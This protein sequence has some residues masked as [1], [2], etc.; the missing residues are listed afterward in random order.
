M[1]DKKNK[2][3][4]KDQAKL[5][6][7]SDLVLK[8]IEY[9][10]EF[11]NAKPFRGKKLYSSK[12]FIH[13]GDNKSA[14]NLYY[15]ADY[16]VHYKCRS[17]GCEKNFGTSLLSMIRGGLSHVKYSWQYPGDKEVSFDDTVAFVLD[18]LQLDFGQ[19]KRSVIDTS[20]HDFCK[21]SQAI[22]REATEGVVSK[23]FYRSRVEIP[24][25]YYIDRGFSI[26]VLDEHDVGTCH[27]YDKPMFNRAMV[28]IYDE[29]ND[30]IVGFTGRSIFEKCSNC[31]SY[32]DPS[33]KCGFFPKWRHSKGLRA[34]N[35]LYN[36][37]KAKS[38]IQESY[39]IILVES[40]GNVW[41]LE[42]AGIHNSV[43]IFGTSLSNTQQ[44][45]IDESGAM[46]MLVIMDNDEPGKQAA[47]AIAEQ[48]HKTYNVQVVPIHSQDVG[49]M[50]VEEVQASIVPWIKKAS[51]N[52]ERF[53]K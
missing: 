28:P 11:F 17:H 14:L 53:L 30:K 5:N 22:N 47:Q 49:D 40:P 26:E 24:A 33:K 46:T 4:F 25:P 6:T 20:N 18:K 51:D 10:Y 42:E 29:N 41:R 27:K 23:E 50:A 39:I 19:L 1:K 9:F 15:N 52:I 2:S 3:P 12:C 8:N 7:L 31:S 48:C 37:G 43:A 45:L 16:R 34:E 44:K 21:L 36:Y 35:I 13:G 38:F 32:H